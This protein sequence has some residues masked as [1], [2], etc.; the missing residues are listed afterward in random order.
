[1]KGQLE[2]Q[3]GVSMKGQL[4]NSISEVPYRDAS[5]EGV[6]GG[7]FLSEEL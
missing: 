6:E 1:V 3:R 2:N 7:G 5:S 4:E